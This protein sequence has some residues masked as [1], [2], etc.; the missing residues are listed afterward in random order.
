MFIRYNE[1]AVRLTGRWYKNENFAVSTAT[2]SKIEFSFYG[3]MAVMHFDMTF[4]E[5]PY[6][7]VWIQVDGGAKVEATIERF[8]RIRADNNGIH[9][10]TVI[11]KSAVEMQHRWYEPLVGKIAFKGFEAESPGTLEP[12]DKKYI[13]FIGD[14]ITEGVYVDEE[15]RLNSDNDMMNRPFQDDVTA[16]YAYITAQSLNLEPLFMGYG[17][18]GLTRIGCGGVPRVGEAYEY[19][20]NAHSTDMP[21]PDYIV[22][23]H[24]ANDQWWD[25]KTEYLSRYSELLDIVYSK[26]PSASVFVLGPFCGWCYEELKNFVEN[27]N[28][29]T[30]RSVV[31]INTHGWIPS[32][33]LHP[34]RDGHKIVAEKLIEFLRKNYIK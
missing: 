4:S 2:G 16:T 32:Q 7:H 24:G 19:C 9:T 14:S 20:F 10:V 12:V 3:D 8:M 22:I 30:G 23:N 11:Y 31:Y 18:V 17:G 13:E 25:D 15:Y 1:P 26:H 34:S 27:Y 29:K 5:H 6:P 33:P 28:L 21:S